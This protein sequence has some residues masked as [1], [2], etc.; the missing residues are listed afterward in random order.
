MECLNELLMH[1][2]SQ[3]DL[4]F[5]R[6]SR[7]RGNILIINIISIKFILFY[8][9]GININKICSTGMTLLGAAAQTGNLS[10]VEALIEDSNS[11]TLDQISSTKNPNLLQLELSSSASSPAT[12]T[13]PQKRCKNI[14]YFVVC[15]DIVVSEENEFGEGPTP[16]GMEALEWDMEVSDNHTNNDGG[17]TETTAE[18]NIYQ[19][20]ASILNRSSIVLKSPDNDIARLDSHGKS[21]LHYAVQSGNLELIRYLV[22]NF[23]EVSVNQTDAASVSPLHIAASKCYLSLVR[24]LVYLLF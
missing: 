5:V 17:S 4:K 14:G 13:T 1:A 8:N 9:V 20:Y 7:K 24:Y 22:D 15:K 6:C 19:W 3:N 12:T 23:N 11:S 10:I 18:I 16:D 2:I 21:V